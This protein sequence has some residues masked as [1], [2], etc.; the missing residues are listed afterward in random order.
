[1]HLRVSNKLHANF[2]HTL[3]CVVPFAYVFSYLLTRCVSDAL[4]VGWK[5]QETESAA[6]AIVTARVACCQIV[7][8]NQISC[9]MLCTV[10]QHRRF[11]Q[12]IYTSIGK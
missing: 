9:T 4:F 7:Y 2:L 6:A 10:G 5:R 12:F 1:M 3:L 11:Y 8:S